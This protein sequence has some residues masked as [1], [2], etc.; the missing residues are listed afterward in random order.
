MGSVAEDLDERCF[1]IA[2]T[3]SLA[4]IALHSFVDFNLYV[5]AHMMM[6]AWIAGAVDASWSRSRERRA[7]TRLRSESEHVPVEAETQYELPVVVDF[8]SR[9][10]WALA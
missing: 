8:A 2:A 4:A 9:V 5:P 1:G 7:S 10:P 3:A 6:V